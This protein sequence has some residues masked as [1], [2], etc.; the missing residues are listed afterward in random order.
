ME[1]DI[2]MSQPAGFTVTGEES[3]LVRRL[4]KSLYGLKQAPRMW[5]QKFDSYIRSVGYHR[6]NSDPCM[7]NRQLADKSRISDPVYRQHAY[8]RQ[9]QVEIEKLKWSLHN[10]FA[11]KELGQARHILGMRIE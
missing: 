3:H 6:S 1:E 4:K 2:Y 11:M 8:C 5:Y 10:K 7:N 9:H